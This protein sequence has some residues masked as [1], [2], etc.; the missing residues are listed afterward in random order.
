[1]TLKISELAEQTTLGADDFVEVSQDTGGGTYA[2]K[3]LKLNTGLNPNHIPFNIAPVSPP[4]TEG[5]VYWDT[6]THL[7]AV[8]TDIAGTTLT[9]GAED[10]VRVINNTGIPIPNGTVIVGQSVTGEAFGI[11]PALAT[12]SGPIGPYAM[13]TSTIADGAEGWATTRGPV[14]NVDTSGFSIMDAVYLSS[15]VAGEYTN[16]APTPPAYSLPIGFAMDS[17]VDGAIYM[18]ASNPVNSI[19]ATDAAVASGDPTGFI[20]NDGITVSYDSIARTIT[21][22]GDLRYSWRGQVK[23]LTSPW[24]STA[25]GATLDTAY[26][27][28]SSDGN[29]F[30]WST[31]A[32]DFPDI[33]VAF[34]WHG[35]T[36]KYALREVHGL[37]PW[38]VHEEFHTTIGSYKTSGGTLGGYTLS[39]VVPA[40]RRP[41]VSAT[42]VKDED[43]RTVLSAHTS[44]LYTKGYLTST[45]IQSFTVETADIVPLSGANPYYNQFVAP[46]WVQTLMTN[47][48]YMCVWLVAVPMASDTNSQ[49]YRYI[50]VQGQTEGTLLEQEALFPSD[51]N[52][53]NLSSLF[54]EFVFCAKAIIRYTS[55]DWRIS[56]V[57]ALT[58]TTANSLGAP[59]GVFL[60]V[61]DT[62]TTLTGDGTAG[63][64]L[65]VAGG[66][67]GSFTTA[68]AK[69]VT[70]TAGIITSIV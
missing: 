57:V 14:R 56:E 55:A 60:S 53:G 59:A 12:T 26:Y 66:A 51:L 8:K 9:P 40:E 70:V 5:T 20:N 34:I 23:E 47:N 35:T 43:D 29:N 67:T 52:F 68:D 13:V 69:T 65:G 33:Q 41:T 30:T 21:L 24:T 2:S 38:Q 28:S 49:K 22:T 46:D 25:H 45:G 61:V 3:K 48:S 37:M 16:V 10:W 15:T 19:H 32:W 54:T 39:S 64:P 17:A 11:V 6:T 7:P 50:W 36:D 63:N 1:M 31:T 58:G 44:L 27:L 4:A 18:Y 42:T 62:D